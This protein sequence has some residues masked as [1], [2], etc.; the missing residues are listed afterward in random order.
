MDTSRITKII[1]RTI[2]IVVEAAITENADIHGTG[3][4]LHLSAFEFVE[5]FGCLG[6][7]SL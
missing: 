6:N 2:E 1:S 3:R 4:C 7:E 5:E